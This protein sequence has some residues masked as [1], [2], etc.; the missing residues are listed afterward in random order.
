M[1][2]DINTL[3]LI[4]KDLR[5]STGETEWPLHQGVRVELCRRLYNVLLP[6]AEDENVDGTKFCL[7]LFP[8]V[9]FKL[10][11]LMRLLKA[12]DNKFNTE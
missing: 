6:A 3:S 4:I 12:H 8:R 2:A 1:K 7:N 11:C 9:L 10:L 5:P